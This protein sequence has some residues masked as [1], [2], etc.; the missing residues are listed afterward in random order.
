VLRIVNT[1]TLALRT[2]AVTLGCAGFALLACKEAKTERSLPDAAMAITSVSLVSSVVPSVPIPL[3]SATAVVSA[4]PSA[5]AVA[6][7]VP[8]AAAPTPPPT[9]LKLAAGESVKSR[10]DSGSN[11]GCYI[12]KAKVGGEE[13]RCPPMAAPGATVDTV[14]TSSGTA[15]PPGFAVSGSDS[16]SRTCVRKS[17]CHGKNICGD[18]HQ[19]VS[20]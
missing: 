12:V 1:C 18:S 15:C 16:C 19:C 9:W 8:D 13:I 11:K 7:A 4:A 20:P 6:D 3:P 10:I 2:V 14:E 17:D 5:L